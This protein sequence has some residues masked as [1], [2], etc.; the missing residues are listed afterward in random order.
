MLWASYV[1]WVAG[2]SYRARDIDD[3]RDA[4]AMKFTEIW[5]ES[6]QSWSWARVASTATLLT[7]LWGFVHVVLKTHAL[8]DALTLGGLSAWAVGPYTVNK[9]TTAF[10]RKDAQL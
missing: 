1:S 2:V 7:A 3:A 5:K 8:P 6:D 9:A 10:A 4:D